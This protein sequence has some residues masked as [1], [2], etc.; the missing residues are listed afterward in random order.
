M[1]FVDGNNVDHVVYAL[2]INLVKL[3]EF[4]TT[5][6]HLIDTYYFRSVQPDSTDKMKGF[7]GW[8]EHHKVR[9]KRKIMAVREVNGKTVTKGNVDVELTL[10]VMDNINRF[11]TLILMTGDRD[12][13][14]LVRYA[15]NQGKRVVLLNTLNI[16]E[17]NVSHDLINMVD[18]FI[19]LS[20]ISQYMQKDDRH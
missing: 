7:L 12:F 9:V 16:A 3:V 10:H 17:P 6:Y 5:P 4:L 13:I 1:L 2:N 15:R 14:E 20:Q 11:D 19:D 18:Q 8:L